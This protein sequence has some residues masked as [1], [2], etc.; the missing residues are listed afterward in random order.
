MKLVSEQNIQCQ[1]T[2]RFPFGHGPCFGMIVFIPHYV[3]GVLRTGATEAGTVLTPLLLG[4]VVCS[5]VGGRLLLRFAFRQVMLAG[6]VLMLAG[7]I[8]LEAMDA[9]SSRVQVLLS[10][11]FLGSGM[12]LAMITPFIAVQY[13]V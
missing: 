4:W 8:L 10:G 13:S 6:M 9:G 7:F 2:Q 1:Q 5:A 12:G 11:A 3:Q